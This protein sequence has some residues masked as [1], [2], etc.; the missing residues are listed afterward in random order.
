MT[1][2]GWKLKAESPTECRL[3]FAQFSLNHFTRCYHA[4]FMILFAAITCL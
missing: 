3:P 2:R 1:A 4:L